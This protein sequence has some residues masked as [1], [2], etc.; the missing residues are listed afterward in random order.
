MFRF[1]EYDFDS[2]SGSLARRD[3]ERRVRR[4]PPQP[5]RL[6]TLLLERAPD[7]VTRD[8]IRNEIWPDVRV[9]FDRSLHF[10]V[11]Q[12]RVA[13]GESAEE[14]RV[15]ETIPRRGYR[16]LVPVTVV[17]AADAPP[18]PRRAVFARRVWVPAAALAALATAYGWTRSTSPTATDAPAAVVRI[19]VMSF[20]TDGTDVPWFASNAIAESLV[21][22][23][24]N[25]SNPRTEVIGPTTTSAYDHDARPLRG[26]IEQYRIDYVLNGRFTDDGS[27]VRLLAEVIQASDGAHVWTRFFDENADPEDVARRVGDGLRD[28]LGA[29]AEPPRA[30]VEG[31]RPATADALRAA[32]WGTNVA[33]LSVSLERIAIGPLARDPFPKWTEAARVPAS[34]ARIEDGEPVL[35]VRGT[36]EPHAW[37]LEALFDCELL[38]DDIEGVP[39]AVTFCTLC[40]TARVWDRRVGDHTLEL[41][42]SGLLVDGG[43]LLYDHGSE[44]LWR[45]VD[46]V[47]V[48]GRYAG[49]RLAAVP[50][51]VMSFGALRSARPDAVVR[52]APASSR[53]AVVRHIGAGDVARGEPPAWLTVSCERPLEVVL[54]VDGDEPSEPAAVAEV[55]TLV[56]VVEHAGEI[57]LFADPTCR[58]IYAREDSAAQ[59]LAGS[60][61]AFDRRVGGRLLTFEEAL[62]GFRDL[63]TGSRWNVLGEAVAGPLEGTRLGLPSQVQ[64]FRFAFPAASP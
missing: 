15:I 21:D 4:L 10:C 12:I 49:T 63:E 51:L 61:F 59:G 29:A 14:P 35:V 41:G 48:A 55:G 9:D 32:G 40:G 23:W 11:R 45:Q 26:L 8:E 31:Y 56:P 5:A 18:P 36:N 1:A 19:A 47:A 3:G 62:A 2:A 20:E 34:A 7:V 42:V 46:G 16:C 57:V 52:T 13:L 64:G 6:L 54:R 33:S 37:P 22:R 60:R 44:S 58:S 17:P 27:R 39:V 50:S 43:A 30:R 24:T 28:V 53:G 38:L 25:T